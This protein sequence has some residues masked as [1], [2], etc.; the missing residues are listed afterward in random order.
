M[1]LTLPLKHKYYE[2]FF[3]ITSYLE[4]W[5][6]KNNDIYTQL[7]INNVILLFN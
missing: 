2:S 4:K 3:H 6:Q 1:F 7:Q 5:Y